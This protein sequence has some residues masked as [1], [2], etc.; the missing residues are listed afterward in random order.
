MTINEILGVL[1]RASPCS[2]VYFA[3]GRC[4][5]TRVA[6]WRGSYD[7]PALGWQPAGYSGCIEKYPTVADLIDELE[8]AISGLPYTG[9]KGG[10]Y[11]YN[12]D[13]TGDCS[14][15]EIDRIEAL[16]WGVILHTST[17][18]ESEF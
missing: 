17:H 7:E 6:S 13:N 12:G 10:E 16:D 15:T 18:V 8:Q 4:V 9:W 3:F 5:P 14:C 2:R 11:W 1:R